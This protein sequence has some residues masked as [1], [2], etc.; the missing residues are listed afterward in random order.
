M[1]ETLAQRFL[2]LTNPKYRGQKE[3]KTVFRI[4]GSNLE[5]ILFHDTSALLF[6][7]NSGEL[8]ARFNGADEQVLVN[9]YVDAQD[10]YLERHYPKTPAWKRHNE[11]VAV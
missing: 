6:E 2:R 5:A 1:S 3:T 10:E 11:G 9:A 4:R 7:H 8:V